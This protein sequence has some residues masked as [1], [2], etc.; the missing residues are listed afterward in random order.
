M[1]G[2]LITGHKQLLSSLFSIVFTLN[3]K[4]EICEE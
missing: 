4:A 1:L 2:N 3:V